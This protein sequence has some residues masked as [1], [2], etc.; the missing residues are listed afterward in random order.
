MCSATRPD[1]AQ[2]VL[3]SQET[4]FEDRRLTRIPSFPHMSTDPSRQDQIDHLKDLIDG[5]R[6]PILTTIDTDGAPWGR[7]MAVQDREFDGDLWFFT[8][9]DSEKIRHIERNDRVGVAFAKPSDQE[10]V[11][12]A[13]RATVSNDRDKIR[14]LWSEPARAWFPDGADDPEIRLIHVEVDRAEYWDSPASVVAFALG[15]AKAVVT[16]ETPDIGDNAK[17][18]L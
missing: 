9:A 18:D 14:A 2:T 5:I 6:T 12:M 4:L 8:R 1:R 10:Y 17:V 13:G 15:Y 11:T 3:N 16:G 7:P